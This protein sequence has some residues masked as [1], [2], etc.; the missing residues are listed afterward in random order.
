MGLLDR[1]DSSRLNVRPTVSRHG[2]SQHSSRGASPSSGASA[3]GAD[4]P[5]Y[6][7]HVSN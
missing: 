3:T 6:A 1:S 2:S 4:R 7:R 5:G